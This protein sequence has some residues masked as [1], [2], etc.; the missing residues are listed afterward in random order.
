MS[1]EKMTFETAIANL[2]NII[3]SME[4]GELELDAL[5]AKFEEGIGLLRVCEGKLK[6]AEG[7]IEVL[8]AKEIAAASAAPPDTAKEE[9]VPAPEEAPPEI[10][11]IEE[12]DSL[13]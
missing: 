8:T 1:K 2:E 11:E 5:L 6:E 7:K 12:E 3:R 13:F 10:P 4:G 9:S